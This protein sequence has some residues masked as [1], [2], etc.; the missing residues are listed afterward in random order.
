MA[1]ARRTFA[2]GSAARA[3]ACWRGRGRLCASSRRAGIVHP[4]VAPLKPTTLHTVSQAAVFLKLGLAC[5]RFSGFSEFLSKRIAFSACTHFVGV[6]EDTCGPFWWS[7]SW[8]GPGLPW[9]RMSATAAAGSAS[10][11]SSADMRQALEEEISRLLQEVF[12]CCPLTL[13]C[14]GAPV[15]RHA[16]ERASKQACVRVRGGGCACV[17]PSVCTCALTSCHHACLRAR[18]TVVILPAG[19]EAVVHPQAEAG[20]SQAALTKRRGWQRDNG[21]PSR[22]TCSKVLCMM[23]FYCMY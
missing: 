14:A 16:S 1:A 6:Q 8:K 23:T 19:E 22:H 18:L 10:V 20:A 11:Q 17:L 13:P 4:Q 21:W 2:V 12:F 9:G 5:R 7:T 3:A 15:E